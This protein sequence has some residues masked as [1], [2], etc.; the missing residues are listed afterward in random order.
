MKKILIKGV[1]SFKVATI[2]AGDVTFKLG[3]KL[4]KGAELA[5]LREEFKAYADTSELTQAHKALMEALESK[6]STLEDIQRSSTTLDTINQ[7]LETNKLAF[8]RRH[9]LFLQDVSLVVDDIDLVVHD[10]REVEAESGLWE[11]EVECLTVLLDCLLEEPSINP[12]IQKEIINI[13]F[14]PTYDVE[15]SKN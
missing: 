8:L 10:T 13:V 3:V 6:E 1:K 9:V 12:L 14:D 7:A 4:Y 11:G 5:G 15:A 2:T